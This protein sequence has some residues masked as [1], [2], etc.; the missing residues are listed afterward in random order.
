MNASEPPTVLHQTVKIIVL[1]CKNTALCVCLIPVYRLFVN[2]NLARR[3]NEAT[4]VLHHANDWQLDLLTEPDLL[5]HV[6][7]RNLL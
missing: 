2:L 5:S 3:A 6:L 7:Q 1:Q 4:H